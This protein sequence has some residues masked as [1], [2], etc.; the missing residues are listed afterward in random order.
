MSALHAKHLVRPVQRTAAAVLICLSAGAQGGE[1]AGGRDP[2]LPPSQ[3]KAPVAAAAASSTASAADITPIV[4]MSAGR[5]YLMD[6]GRRLGVGDLYGTARIARIDDNG[7]WLR[8]ADS[9]E[10]IPLHGTVA[11]KAVPPTSE[12]PIKNNPNR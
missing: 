4:I 11:R 7:V 8:E 10:Q 6:R 2:T 5:Y 3:F 12:R 9:L 1:P